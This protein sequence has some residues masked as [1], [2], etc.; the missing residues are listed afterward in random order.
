MYLTQSN[1]EKPLSFFPSLFYIVGI[2][3]AF[4]NERITVG[5]EDLAMAIPRYFSIESLR[6]SA[7]VRKNIEGSFLKLFSFTLSLS[8]WFV[9]GSI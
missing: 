9:L 2:L 3:K 6:F 1:S 7:F 5:V 4:Q 8:N